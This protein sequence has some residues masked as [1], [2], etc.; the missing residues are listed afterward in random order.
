MQD[1]GSFTLLF[2]QPI[3]AL[4]V[5]LDPTNRAPDAPEEW[6]WVKPIPGTITVNVADTLSFLTGGYLKSSVHR[7]VMP[8]EDQRHLSRYSVIYFSRPDDETKLEAVESPVIKRVGNNAG[9]PPGMLSF[10]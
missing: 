7:V 2:M 6:K 3:A 4:Q 5:R 1:F 10:P 8:P 9:V